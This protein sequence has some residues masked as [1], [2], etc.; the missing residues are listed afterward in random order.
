M[1]ANGHLPRE[2]AQR[3]LRDALGDEVESYEQSGRTLSVT[4]AA[5][6]ALDALDAA[7]A[8]AS[9]EST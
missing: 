3:A 2:N 5:N 8:S 9:E 6:V 1:I 4:Q 7:L